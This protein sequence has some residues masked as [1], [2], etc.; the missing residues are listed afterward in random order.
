MLTRTLRIRPSNVTDTKP[1]CYVSVSTMTPL[2]MTPLTV[3]L[4]IIL[5][6]VPISP[7]LYRIGNGLSASS[8][9]QYRYG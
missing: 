6:F 1:K 5:N 4:F 2:T 8:I 3:T 9:L 7:S